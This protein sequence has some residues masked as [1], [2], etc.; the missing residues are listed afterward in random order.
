[1][2]SKKVFDYT[3][4][5]KTVNCF[6]IKNKSGAFV[7]VL[8]YGGIIR[9]LCVP[10][11]NGNLVDVVIGFERLSPYLKNRD[12]YYGAFVGRFANR[13][14]GGRFTLDGVNYSVEKNNGENHLHGGD[15]SFS[16]RIASVVEETDNSVTLAWDS[17]HMDQGYPGH[18]TVK[19]KY[20][21]DDKNQLTITY[22]CAVD[23][24]SLF[25]PTNHSYF[26]MN[27]PSRAYIGDNEI[28]LYADRFTPVNDECIPLGT[29]QSVRGALDMRVWTK[30]DNVLKKEETDSNLQAGCGID[31]NFLVRDYKG[32]GTVLRAA[33]LYGPSTGIRMSVSTDLPGIQLYSANYVKDGLKGKVGQVYGRRCAI[34]FETQ[35][36]PD[37][38][39][40]PEWPSPVIKAGETKEYTTVF[41]FDTPVKAT[42]LDGH[43]TNPGDISWDPL[44]K[45]CRA[46][47]YDRTARKDVLRRIRGS[48]VVITNK[49]VLDREL[50]EEFDGVKYVG[51]L[52]TGANAVDREALS[53]RGIALTNVPGYSTEDVAQLTFS[54]ILELC[55]K[56]AA[57][58]AAVKD[59]DW[60]DSDDFCFTVS[61][62]KE[63]AGSTLGIIGYGAIGSRVCEIA[64]AFGM[65]VLVHSRS[66]K[67]L[68]EGARFVSRNELLRKS[69][70]VTLHLPLT[71]KTA[72]YIDEEAL[73]IMKDGAILI[74]TSRG[75]VIDEQAVADAL[76][77]G[78]LSGAGL[79]VLSTEPPKPDNPLLKAPNT[80][81]TPHIGWAA[82]AARIR[83]IEAVA[84]NIS[85]FNSGRKLNRL[86]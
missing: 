63:L 18:M 47:I 52:S 44:Y 45:I 58:D 68:P 13:I 41:A 14:A 1:M 50:I 35:F 77:S 84:K 54:L 28:K 26:N 42:V 70:I 59:G 49:C 32:D 7:D 19:V 48:E 16:E 51:L 31:H 34:C 83:L 27:G 30:L 36:Y 37:S 65:K 12:A 62:I 55:E 3:K 39:N 4:D 71:E 29:L 72:C 43:T 53:E 56:A 64:R 76:K 6:R 5:G 66:E 23:K 78:K 10:D 69:D 80:V 46:D 38:V 67:E 82:Q 61:P 73:S 22:S 33:E 57:H 75:G 17:P 79:D 40:H 9:S 2:L 85:A 25:N 20:A 11:R 21:F 15:G 81:I 74:N 86:D 24:D 60:C 8:D